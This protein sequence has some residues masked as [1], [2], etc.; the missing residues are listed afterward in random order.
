M[1]SIDASELLRNLKTIE[2]RILDSARI[3]M[4]TVVK[5]AYRSIKEST[6]FKD[7]TQE[8]R[9]TTDIVDLGAFKKRLIMRAPWAKYVNDGT[10]PHPIWPKAAKSFV[11]PVRAGQSRGGKGSH[12]LRFVIGGRVVFARMVNHPGTEPRPVLENAAAAGGQAMKIILEEGAERAVH[13]P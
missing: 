7:R 11:G 4:D 13:Y 12:L 9:G 10:R 5:V 1:I 2:R 3:G 6:L 8:L